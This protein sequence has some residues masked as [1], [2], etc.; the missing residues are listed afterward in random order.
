MAVGRFVP[1]GAVVGII[2]AVG[3][4]AHAGGALRTVAFSPRGGLVAAG[5]DGGRVVWWDPRRERVLADTHRHR[6]AVRCV[7]FSPNGR[8]LAS[9]GDDRRIGLWDA[10]TRRCLRW[11]RGH[12]AAVTAL[13]F[14]PDGR[15]LYSTG[16]DRTVRAWSVPAG[17]LLHLWRKFMTEDVTRVGGL[18]VSRSGLLLVG[19]GSELDGREITCTGDV[20]AWRLPGGRQAWNGDAAHLGCVHDLRLAPRG[21][22]FVTSE[23]HESA[24]TGF[25]MQENLPSESQLGEARLW[26]LATGKSVRL[27]QKGLSYAPAI[28][29]AADDRLAVGQDDGS[30]AIF[31]TD[32]GKPVRVGMP[33]AWVTG[34]AFSPAEDALAVVDEKGGIHLIRTAGGS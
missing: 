5:G 20:Q 15:T 28:A 34:L 33:G 25:Q 13:A 18:A 6:G 12:T 26:N 16:S 24:R 4:V 3:A 2:L 29:F 30:V 19:T 9:A 11:L 1:W 10:R 21:R 7:R 17:R 22:W 27:F 14:A 8:W 31:P 23:M 32:G